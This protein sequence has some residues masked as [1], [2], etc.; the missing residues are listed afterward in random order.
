MADMAQPLPRAQLRGERRA[1]A[2]A[3]E[4]SSDARIRHA[5]TPTH[6]HDTRP[7]NKNAHMM[8]LTR[9]YCTHD[10]AATQ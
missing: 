1:P 3:Y 10:A 5:T 6:K 2:L 8:P 9:M 7:R 4:N